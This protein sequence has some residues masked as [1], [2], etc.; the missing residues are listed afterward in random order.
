MLLSCLL[1]GL[2]K[3]FFVVAE[4]LPAAVLVVAIKTLKV[5][6]MKAA[7]GV[8]DQLL[9]FFPLVREKYISKEGIHLLQPKKQH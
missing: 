8:L 5:A 2:L 6:V 1:M 7:E 4:A 9:N 3:V